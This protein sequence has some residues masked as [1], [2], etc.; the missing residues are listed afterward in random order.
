M[1]AKIYS[2]S[3]NQSLMDQVALEYSTENTT[4]IDAL[5]EQGLTAANDGD[6]MTSDECFNRIRQKL[7]AKHS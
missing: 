6:T 4:Q 3:F 5:I 7:M 1:R 2:F